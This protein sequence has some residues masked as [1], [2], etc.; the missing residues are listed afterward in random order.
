MKSLF[1]AY[2]LRGQKLR[3]RVVMA[4][5]TRARAKDGIADQLTPPATTG[6]ALAPV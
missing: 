6:S 5:M 1:E 3:N 2:D 4:P